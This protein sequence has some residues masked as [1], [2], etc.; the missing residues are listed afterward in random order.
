MPADLVVVSVLRALVEVAGY[1][2]LA[3]GLLH[4]ISGSRRERNPIYRLFKLLTSP[5]IR[6]ARAVTPKAVLDRHVPFVAF[7]L[8]FWIWI[9]LAIVKLRL[10][11]WHQVVCV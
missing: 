3:Q 7:F 2:L 10:C 5:V 11:A 6:I 9:G 4:L 1:F 8:L